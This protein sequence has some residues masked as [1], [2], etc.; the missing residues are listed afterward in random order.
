MRLLRFLVSDADRRAIES[1]L[2][3]LF[4]LHRRH[5]GEV[6]AARWLRRQRLLYPMHVAVDRFRAA[7]DGGLSGIAHVVRAVPYSARSLA[8]TPA[9]ARPSC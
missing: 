3:E 8:R 7:V 4:E 1:D 9:L 5:D 2:S 6:A